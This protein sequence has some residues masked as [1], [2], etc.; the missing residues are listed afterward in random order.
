ME[1]E[2]VVTFIKAKET[3]GQNNLEKQTFV[4]EEDTDREYKNSMCVDVFGDKTK[5]LDW[6]KKWDKVVAML[7]TRA[8][9]Y[10][11]RWFN[12]ITARKL[13]VIMT[14]NKENETDTPF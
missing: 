7:N 1:F 13:D 8:K 5:L 3:V 14:E 12:T 10:N 4:L 2:W 11:G 9:E 6:L